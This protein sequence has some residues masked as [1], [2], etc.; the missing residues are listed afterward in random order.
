MITE[1]TL[2]GVAS[3]KKKVTLTTDRKVNIIYGLNGSGKSTFSNYFYDRGNP[4]YNQCSHS[5]GDASILV[6][7]QGNPPI[8]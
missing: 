4:K 6:Y 7:N 5:V 3:Y 8:N 2:D 1:I